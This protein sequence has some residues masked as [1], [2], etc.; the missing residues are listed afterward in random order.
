VNSR[1]G[2]T[3]ATPEG[4][5]YRLSDGIYRIMAELPH[6]DELEAE[7]FVEPQRISAELL[8]SSYY[9]DFGQAREPTETSK[10]H[11]STYSKIWKWK[12]L[13]A[14]TSTLI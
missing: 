12:H 6:S 9:E 8:R 3:P 1:Q 7:D 4:L 5:E 11:P 13:K 2:G 14:K 10:P